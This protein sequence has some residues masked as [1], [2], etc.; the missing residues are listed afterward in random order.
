MDRLDKE[1]LKAI[2]TE[3][4]SIYNIDKNI[5]DS[6]Y[7]TV[8]RHIK[9]MQKDN[10]LV[11]AGARRKNGKADK[12]KTKIPELTRKGLATL[13]IEGD[14]QKEELVSVGKKFFLRYFSQRLL[15]LVNPVM[16]NI[17][18]DAMLRIKPKVNLRFFD[19]KY[20]DELLVTSF[21][22]SLVET[23]PKTN[24][25]PDPKQLEELLNYSRKMAKKQG[26]EKIF[27]KGLELGKSL[28]SKKE[29]EG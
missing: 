17:F 6:N 4:Q 7:A 14:L 15:E 13:L 10:L 20:F 18:T 27:E 11:V 19:E 24:I 12:R 29:K 21:V 3:E 28:R 5:K 23:L 2:L 25:K 16:A 26:T 8:W 1:I 9:N 22:E